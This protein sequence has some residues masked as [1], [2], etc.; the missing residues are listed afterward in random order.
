MAEIGEKKNAMDLVL[1]YLECF[2]QIAI[3]DRKFVQAAAENSRHEFRFITPEEADHHAFFGHPE[4]LWDEMKMLDKSGFDRLKRQS[5][6]SNESEINKEEAEFSRLIKNGKSI[7]HCSRA[8]G[9]SGYMGH[10]WAKKLGL[11]SQHG[12][13]VLHSIQSKLESIQ[14]NDSKRKPRIP[15]SKEEDKKLLELRS[16]KMPGKKI[17]EIM[18]RTAGAI[19]TRAGVLKA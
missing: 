11:K 12:N 14:S 2:D 4:I 16:Q 7:A 1:K 13:A 19:F 9:I 6:E 10:K 8:T 18:G 17:A 3:G 15:W 5:V